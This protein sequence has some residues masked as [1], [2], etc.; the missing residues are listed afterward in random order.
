MV[1]QVNYNAFE[2]SNQYTLSVPELATGIYLIKCSVD[3]K[4]FIKKVIVTN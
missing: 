1:K 4:I 2:G 3:S